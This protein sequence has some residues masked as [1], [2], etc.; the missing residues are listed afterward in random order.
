MIMIWFPHFCR[1]F[2]CTGGEKKSLQPFRM[3][4]WCSI[5]IMIWFP[6]F[7]RSFYC[8]GGEKKSSQLFRMYW[9]VF[10]HRNN[11]VHRLFL[12][13]WGETTPNLVVECH[14]DLLELYGSDWVSLRTIAT[15]PYTCL[16][17]IVVSCSCIY[18]MSVMS[19]KNKKIPPSLSLSRSSNCTLKNAKLRRIC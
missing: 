12:D 5:M 2:Y 19:H 15:V 10:Y 3:Y 14:H 13:W 1:S 7:C 9:L 8:T 4:C 6:H 18:A 17:T 16:L 11:P